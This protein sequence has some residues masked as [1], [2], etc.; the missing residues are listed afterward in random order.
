MDYA[1]SFLARLPERKRSI[2][3]DR[4][5]R[6]RKSRGLRELSGLDDAPD[7]DEEDNDNSHSDNILRAEASRIL[8]D[9][10]ALSRD[11]RLIT[12]HEVNMK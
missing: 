3:L 12:Q 4:L 11:E 8:G 5:N 7:D 1:A 9:I 10:I 6:Y 2:G